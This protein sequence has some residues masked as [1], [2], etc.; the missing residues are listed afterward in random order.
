MKEQLSHLE[1]QKIKDKKDIQSVLKTFLLDHDKKDSISDSLKS[2]LV[3]K[4]ETLRE[5]FTQSHFFQ[6]HE[7]IGSSLL[8]IHDGVSKLGV[9]MIDFAKT[10]P[11]PKEVMI[12]H[13][14][15]WKLGNHEDGYLFGL[16]NLISMVDA[17]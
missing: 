6:S 11:L 5:Q 2:Q 1:F 17:L 4:L 12:N 10:V 9:W 13:R 16:D 7:V 3:S 8:V 14:T 15:P